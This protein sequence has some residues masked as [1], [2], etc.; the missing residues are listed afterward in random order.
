MNEQGKSPCAKFG[1]KS[2]R[3]P[4]RVKSSM[5]EVTL[6]WSDLQQSTREGGR[7]GR[8]NKSQSVEASMLMFSSPS[9]EER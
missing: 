7:I 5:T 6:D 1:R 3:I 8:I 4:C 9:K 2:T